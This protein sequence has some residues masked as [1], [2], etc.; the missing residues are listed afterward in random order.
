ME[1]TQGAGAAAPLICGGN[2][3]LRAELATL[4]GSFVE[5]LGP[6]RGIGQKARDQLRVQR[7][8]GLVGFDARQKRAPHQRQV[9]DQIERL[10]P[11]EFVREAQR[12]I[13]HAIFVEDDGVVER[14][15]TDQAHP[16]HPFEVLHEAERPRRR[17]HPAE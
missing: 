12:T 1:G 10:M 17:Q 6:K 4:G 2:C 14:A 7:V 13:H 16:P 11:P 9:P 15:A 3:G 8:P 5:C